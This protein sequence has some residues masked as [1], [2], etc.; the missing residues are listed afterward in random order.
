MNLAAPLDGF[1]RERQW[2]GKGNLRLSPLSNKSINF[3][4]K[5]WNK[6]KFSCAKL[7][8]LLMPVFNYFAGNNPKAC[9]QVC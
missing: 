2:M 6:M 7:I 8:S 9:A 1:D 5:L 3:P 4:L